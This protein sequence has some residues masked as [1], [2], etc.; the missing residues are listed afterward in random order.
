MLEVR[1]LSASYGQHPALNEVSLKVSPGEIVVILGANGAGKSSLLRAIAGICEGHVSGEMLLDGASLSGL[2]PD[3]IV[4]SGVALVPEGRGIFGDLTVRENLLLGAYS[5]RARDSE[6]NNLERVF[7][8][9]PTLKE[10]GKQVARTMS[11]GEQ[12]MVAIGR[13]MMSAPRILLLDEPSLGLS[14]RLCKELFRSLVAVR[15]IGVG[16]LLVEQNARQSLVIADRGYVLENSRI[17]RENSAQ[18]LMSDPAVQKAYLGAGSSPAKEVTGTERNV[19]TE[20]P[21]APTI[22]VDRRPARRTAEQQIS[23][24]IDD[25]VTKAS[26]SSGGPRPRHPATSV[27]SSGHDAALKAILREIETAAREARKTGPSDEEPESM[28]CPLP[29]TKRGN[30]RPA[31]VI[32]IYRR[33]PGDAKQGS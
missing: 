21:P 27:S 19:V 15:E 23:L 4:E 26:R 14:P 10:R 24:S 6:S 9:F 22:D 25:L 16:I 5:Q 12:Q 7:R 11:G 1:S 17:I 31:P 8:L 20:V 30:E 2:G 3:K 18:S 13:A 29:R 33:F 28:P 32:E